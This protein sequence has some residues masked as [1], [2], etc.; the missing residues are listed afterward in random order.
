VEELSILVEFLNSKYQTSKIELDGDK[1]TGLAGLFMS[2]I[3][4]NIENIV[5]RE[6]PVSYLFNTRKGVDFFSA[7][8]H[9]PGIL[10]W[11][12]ISLAVALTG[13]N[14]L[15]MDPAT[16]SGNKVEGERLKTTKEEF[17]KISGIC[18]SYGR[19]DFR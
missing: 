15:F 13:T 17:D 2:S 7:A 4:G 8:V 1:E 14:V 18:N 6:A 11:G 9:I 16:M 12:D 5:L 10:K 19:I 3:E